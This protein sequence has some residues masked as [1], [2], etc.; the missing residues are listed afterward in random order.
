MPTEVT[1]PI[2]PLG[3]VLLPGMDLPLHIFEERY[4]ILIG[5]CLKNDDEFGVV[6]YSGKMI[7]RVGCT[8][9]ITEI[10]RNYD[11][12]KMDIMTIGKRR[13][14]I[15]DIFESKEY[16]EARV[17]FFQDL[18]IEEDEVMENL[19]HRGKH[20]LKQLTSVMGK[21]DDTQLLENLDPESLSF[22]IAATHGFT[23]EEKQK[24][25]ELTS[26]RQRLEMSIESLQ[27][28]IERLT[29]SKEI[30]RIFGGKDNSVD[31][32]PL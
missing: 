30:K 19:I 28:I 8:A 10:L 20:E 24:F 13:F 12:G 14:H 32:T 7:L 4:K 16:L 2:F 1:I 18:P 9:K 17:E 22:L 27:K 3:V 26:T 15:R 29:L 25:L 31:N 23:P 6:Y 21:R 5:E 11:D